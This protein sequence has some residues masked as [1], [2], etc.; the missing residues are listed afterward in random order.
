MFDITEFK[1]FSVGYQGSKK[2][3]KPYRSS[4]LKV[5]CCDLFN[6]QNKNRENELPVCLY[7]INVRFRITNSQCCK[8]AS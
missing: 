7:E 4:I 8:S 3:P 6:Q 2:N 1:P 5:G